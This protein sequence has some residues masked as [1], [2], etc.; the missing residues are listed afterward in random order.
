MRLPF[1]ILGIGLFAA[2]LLGLVIPRF[3]QTTGSGLQV[4]LGGQK[5]VQAESTAGNADETRMPCKV[6]T[7][8]DGDTLG[9]DLNGNGKIEQPGEEIRLLGI[10]SPEMH[11]SKKNP[12]HDSAHPVDEPIAPEASRWLSKRTLRKTVWL[13][14]D[15]RRKDRYDRTLAYIYPGEKTTVSLNEELLAEGYAKVLF[16]G[17]NRRYETEFGAAEKEARVGRRGLWK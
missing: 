17:R 14:F 7:V 2:G 5:S 12:T 15:H 8:Y 6:L 9:C 10:D 13:E 1:R 3:V 16:L 4:G 11:Y